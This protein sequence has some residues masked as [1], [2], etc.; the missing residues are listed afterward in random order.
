MDDVSVE[1]TR[2]CSTDVLKPIPTSPTPSAPRQRP[3]PIGQVRMCQCKLAPP[4]WWAA[5]SKSEIRTCPAHVPA[6]ASSRQRGGIHQINDRIKTAKKW[7]GDTIWRFTS[8]SFSRE[9]VLR[10]DLAGGEALKMRARGGAGAL[11]S[12]GIGWMVGCGSGRPNHGK[13]P[14]TGLCDRTHL[15]HFPWPASSYPIV[16]QV[17]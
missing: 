9:S 1:L 12:C 17:H 2:G 3:S 14:P 4:C 10:G 15:P 5:A 6:R 7:R 16:L 8:S 13:P 11:R